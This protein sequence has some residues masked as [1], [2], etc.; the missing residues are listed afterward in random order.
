MAMHS[1]T[2]LE[3]EDIQ[4]GAL[5][6]RPTPY[7]GLYIGLRIDDPAQGRELL[8]RVLPGLDSA[9]GFDSH[10]QF[11][12]AVALTYTGLEALGLPQ[13]SLESFPDDFRQ[14]MAARADELG[15]VGENGPNWF[16]FRDGISQPRIEGLEGAGGNP[17]ETPL[18]VGEFIL[19]YEDEG[20]IL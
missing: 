1:Q 9:A 7:S 13:E 17:Q 18:K 5:Q 3:L 16:G 20:G 4:A 14:G 10:R 6:E 8:R 19:G 15:D 12:L 2:G 11:S